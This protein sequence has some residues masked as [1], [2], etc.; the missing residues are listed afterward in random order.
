MSPTPEEAKAAAVAA[1]VGPGGQ[2]LELMRR[3]EELDEVLRPLVRRAVAAGVPKTRIRELTGLA[4]GTVGAWSKGAES[5]RS[6]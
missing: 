3:V 2:R 4:R 1:L 6:E 5:D